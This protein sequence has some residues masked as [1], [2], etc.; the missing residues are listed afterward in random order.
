[1]F[2][3]CLFFKWISWWV[4]VWVL[5]HVDDFLA[6]ATE[7]TLIKELRERIDKKYETT[8]NPFTEYL[9]I[10]VTELPDNGGEVFTRTSQLRKIF[11]QWPPQ[12]VAGRGPSQSMS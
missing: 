10:T 8:G 6:T 2:D 12:G 4:F 11:D 5:I 3:K 7:E 9:G 1:M